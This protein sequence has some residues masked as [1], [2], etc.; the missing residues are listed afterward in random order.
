[1]DG[2]N[3]LINKTSFIYNANTI[4]LFYETAYS[5]EFESYLYVLVL[6]VL[7]PVMLG[8][9]VGLG[10]GLLYCFVLKII[11]IFTTDITEIH[12]D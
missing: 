2:L 7:S 6:S 10:E 11:Y 5:Y 3:K 12:A 8:L 1:M 9:G 4:Q